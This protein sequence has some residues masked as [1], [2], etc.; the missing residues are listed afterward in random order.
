MCAAMMVNVCGHDDGCVRML[1]WTGPYM[2]GDTWP[3]YIIK[4]VSYVVCIDTPYCILYL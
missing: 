2:M 1:W 4:G 3:A